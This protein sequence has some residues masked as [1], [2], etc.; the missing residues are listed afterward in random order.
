MMN[1]LFF[2]Y[3]SYF[4]YLSYNYNKLSFLLDELPETL[5]ELHCSNNEFSYIAKKIKSFILCR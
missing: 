4:L 3:F 5:E 1:N 2:F